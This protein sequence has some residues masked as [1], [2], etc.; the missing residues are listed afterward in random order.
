M[1]SWKVVCVGYEEESAYDDCRAINIIGKEV[2][3]NLREKRVD[4][5][6]SQI[7]SENAA[8]HLE[9]DGQEIPLKP[10]KHDSKMYVRTMDED[11]VEDPLLDLPTITEYE[12]DEKFSSL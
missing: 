6:A 4:M 5:V 9:V 7:A 3:H 1:Y 10:A 11:S 2:A 12:L 8:Y